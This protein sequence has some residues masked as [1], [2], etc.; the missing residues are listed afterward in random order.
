MVVAAIHYADPGNVIM[1]ISKNNSGAHYFSSPWTTQEF[2]LSS[3][4]PHC[5]LPKGAQLHLVVI[6]TM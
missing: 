6:V 4:L 3:V 1:Y 2:E 5:S